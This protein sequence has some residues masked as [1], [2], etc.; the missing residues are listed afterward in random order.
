M[1]KYF[2]SFAV[3]AIATF[4]ISTGALAQA[5][6]GGIGIGGTT[7]TYS[8]NATS[9]GAVGNLV[10]GGQIGTFSQSAG[11]HSYASAGMAIGAVADTTLHFASDGIN[12]GAIGLTRSSSAT[13]QGFGTAG[14][15]TT[16]TYEGDGLQIGIGAHFA[17][18]GG[19]ASSNGAFAGV[20]LVAA[21]AT[22]P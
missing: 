5:A 4:G 10:A 7:G 2:A 21:V 6:A 11:T 12:N 19:N 17:A 9:A 20:G 22:S 1:L 16:I 15:V 3:A 8:A 14:S 13:V 18:S